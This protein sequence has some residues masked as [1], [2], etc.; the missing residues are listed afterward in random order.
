MAHP[1]TT[2]RCLW[3]PVVRVCVHLHVYVWMH[4]HEYTWAWMLEA[5]VGDPPLTSST[6]FLRQ[7]L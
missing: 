6:L 1:I 2:A 4:T 3:V 5:S 7:G